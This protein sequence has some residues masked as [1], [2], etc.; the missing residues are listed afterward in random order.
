MVSK[1]RTPTGETGFFRRSGRCTRPETHALP[2]A[3]LDRLPGTPP[4]VHAFNA[5][6]TS[7]HS[8]PPTGLADDAAPPQPGASDNRPGD[9]FVQSFARGL[10][11]IRSFSADAP[12]QS[13]TDVARRCGLTRAGAR[14]I[15]LTLQSLGYVETQGRLF[16]LTPKILDLGFAYL[17]SLPLWHLA[18]PVME[19]LV[20]QVKE[21][22][23]AALLDGSDIVYVLR[24]PTQKIMR[25]HLGVGSRLPAFCTSMGR[26]LLAALPAAEARRRLEA[27]PRPSF[28]DRTVVDVD[29][30]MALLEQTRQQGWCLVDQELETGLVSMAAPLHDR[31]GRVIAALNIGTQAGRMSVPALQEQVLP[32]LLE[33][34]HRISGLL[35]RGS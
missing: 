12:T 28:T 4:S 19:E 20:A 6:M 27:S 9:R 33:A 18:E 3:H 2:C 8:S 5:H 26:V 31:S 17:S 15:L 25:V 30:L 16:R 29:A 21:S 14:R 10:E 13:L 1:P 22:C 32:R 7:P 11:V 24:V 23:S 35:A 34:A